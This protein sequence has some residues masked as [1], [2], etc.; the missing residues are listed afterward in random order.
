[1]NEELDINEQ[2]EKIFGK[3]IR[4]NVFSPDDEEYN[5][6]RQEILNSTSEFRYSKNLPLEGIKVPS[7]E[8]FRMDKIIQKATKE[9]KHIFNIKKYEGE[10]IVAYAAAYFHSTYSR[11]RVL[12]ESFCQ[13]SH[14]FNL[15]CETLSI[16][17]N[18]DLR[19]S[20]YAKDG[21]L[22]L[23]RNRSFDSAS[24]AASIFLGIKATFREWKDSNGN[25]LAEHIPYYKHIN[26]NYLEERSFPHVES[27]KTQN[28][29]KGS[30]FENP[31]NDYEADLQRKIQLQHSSIIHSLK[32]KNLIQQNKT[33]FKSE[34]KESITDLINTQA[35]IKKNHKRHLFYTKPNTTTTS[36]YFGIGY[37]DFITRKFHILSGSLLNKNVSPTYAYSQA[38]IRRL[39]ILEKQC[40]KTE[41]GY[42]ANQD[43]ECETPQAAAFY[44]SGMPLDGW[45]FWID[46]NNQ[47]LYDVYR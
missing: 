37:Y 23:K 6:L 4:P 8:E 3:E 20:F 9:G 36:Q 13:E 11:F 10:K 29:T 28:I 45:K 47:N 34:N 43:I 12:E 25:T 19:D 44:I 39:N 33:D 38:N 27:I 7:Y 32:K 31:V 41:K 40:T 16:T 14:Y 24:L 2:Y 1:M 46:S 30:T 26:I 17:K 35:I 18:L 42:I 21:F 22:Y 15:I 5:S